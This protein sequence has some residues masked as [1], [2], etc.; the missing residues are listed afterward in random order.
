MQIISHTE[1]FV[2][3]PGLYRMPAEVYHSDPA[4]Q[5]SLSSSIAKCIIKFTPAHAR[6]KHPRLAAAEQ[7]EGLSRVL[8]A[9]ASALADEGDGDE[10][11]KPD[12]VNI[13]SVAHELLLGHGGGFEVCRFKDWR[14]KD[15][16][17]AKAEAIAAHKVPILEK[18]FRRAV[19]IEVAVRR[20]MARVAPG[21]F[22][23]RGAGEVVG[24]WADEVGCYGR[25]M[26]DWVGP[27]ENVWNLKTTG[28]GLD[29]ASID[30]RIRDDGID[31][32]CMWYERGLGEV[33]PSLRGRLTTRLV[34]VEQSP[35]HEVRIVR[36]DDAGHRWLGERKAAIASVLFAHGVNTGE[37]PGYPDDLDSR[38]SCA[39]YAMKQWE[40]RET[41]D[42]IWNGF[43]REILLANSSFRPIQQQPAPLQLPD[44]SQ[45]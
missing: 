31:L 22:E 2:R 42:P 40:D 1:G 7:T 26:A 32:Q 28:L 37:W 4:P 41:T 29:D 14:T 21:V 13:G 25:L 17:A 16:K 36:F 20:K 33:D 34:F 35:P 11:D 45:E 8:G 3:G 10:E 19:N 39:K 23:N 9:D 15:A 44:Y 24:V 12:R 38:V 27:G 6:A 18:H 43:G 30:R 5:P